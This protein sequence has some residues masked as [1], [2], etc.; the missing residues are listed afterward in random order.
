M[1]T[2][3]RKS[4]TLVKKDRLVGNKFDAFFAARERSRSDF[5]RDLKPEQLV[6]EVLV[7]QVLEFSLKGVEQV[8]F[9][10]VAL[11]VENLQ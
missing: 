5:A 2:A 8:G 1:T 6:N 7:A 11:L 4:F 10:H 9:W 3:S